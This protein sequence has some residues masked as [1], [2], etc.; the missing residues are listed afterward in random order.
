MKICKKCKTLKPLED[1]YISKSNLDGRRG[2]C[3]KC[4][5]KKNLVYLKA[6]GYKHQRSNQFDYVTTEPTKST[7][8]RFIN[9]KYRKNY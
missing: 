7:Q 3:K 4:T 6:G 8:Y 5:V 2:M 9:R 1:F